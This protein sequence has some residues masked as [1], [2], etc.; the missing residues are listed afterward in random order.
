MAGKDASILERHNFLPK[1]YSI[2]KL[3]EFVRQILDR[4]VVN[5]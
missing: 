1:P 5:N 4:Q 3:A 2:G